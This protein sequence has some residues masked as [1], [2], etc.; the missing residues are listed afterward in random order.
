MRVSCHKVQQNLSA[1]LDGELP[2]TQKETIAQHLMEC[3][4]CCREYAQL[5]ATNTALHNWQTSEIDPQLSVIFARQL[6]TRATSVTLP[7]QRRHWSSLTWAVGCALMLMVAIMVWPHISV[8]RHE[9]TTGIIIRQGPTKPLPVAK[10]GNTENHLVIANNPLKQMKTIG[11]KQE[12]AH[13]R[14][15]Y[16]RNGYKN[17]RDQH[18]L[19]LAS[20]RTNGNNPSVRAANPV[21]APSTDVT[22]NTTAVLSETV[23]ASDVLNNIPATLVCSAPPESPEIEIMTTW[24]ETF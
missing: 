13:T 14:R 8:Q 22:K 18:R 6:A 17:I 15:I 20:T 1:Y 7:Q 11:G 23:D 9:I 5:S 21:T 10:N 2:I 3:H 12:K 19:L 16:A 24:S 4:D